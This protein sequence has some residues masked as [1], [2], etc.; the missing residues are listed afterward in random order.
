MTWP[1]L[2]KADQLLVS[3]GGGGADAEGVANASQPAE[4][5]AFCGGAAAVSASGSSKMLKS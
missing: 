5:G 3:G 2:S 1:P 4:G